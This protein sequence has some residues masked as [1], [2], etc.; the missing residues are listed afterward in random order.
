MPELDAF[1]V[2]LVAK[3]GLRIIRDADI[4]DYPALLMDGNDASVLQQVINELRD[5][6]RRTISSH[7]QIGMSVPRKPLEPEGHVPVVAPQDLK[8]EQAIRALMRRDSRRAVMISAYGLSRQ[9]A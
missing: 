5:R 9:P 6:G 3:I 7:Q 1:V 8:S 2:K 4:G